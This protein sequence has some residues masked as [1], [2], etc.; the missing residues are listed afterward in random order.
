MKK[1]VRDKIP[2]IAG[3]KAEFDVLSN[4]EY[5]TSLRDKLVE[6]AKEVQASETRALSRDHWRMPSRLLNALQVE[7]LRSVSSQV[8][9][10]KRGNCCLLWVKCRR[11]FGILFKIYRAP[12]ISW[13]PLQKS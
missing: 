1:L 4:D 10:T 9:R 3:D 13:L 2:D 8:A 7:I 6:E 11:A 5:R 12:Q